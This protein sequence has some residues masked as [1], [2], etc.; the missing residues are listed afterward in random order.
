VQVF[1]RTR[2][3]LAREAGDLPAV[4]MDTDNDKVIVCTAP[5]AMSCLNE[6]KE[7]QMERKEKTYKLDGVFPEDA[8]QKDVFQRVGLP[9]L[10]EVMKG[11]NGCIFAY[12]QTGSGKTHS[13][14]NTEVSEMEQVGILPRLV[15]TLYA[16]AAM[17]KVHV[18]SVKAAGFQVYNEQVDDLLHPEHKRGKGA[19]LSINK[20]GG[21]PDLTWVECSSPAA[22]L[23]LFKKARHGLFYA[24]TSMN[25]ASS[26]SHAVFQIR[27]VRRKRVKQDNPD[28]G[29]SRTMQATCGQLSV[30]DLAGSERVKR[31]GVTGSNFKEATNINGSLL[32]LGNVI[33]A[34]ADKRKHI[35]FR[36]SKLTRILEGSVGGN[37]KTSLLV[38]VSPADT[39]TS[40]TLSTLEFASRAMC[41]EVDAKVNETVV[42]IDAARLA[43]DMD[44]TDGA[45]YVD[46]EMMK[47]FKESELALSE[48]KA[49]AAEQ[50]AAAQTLKAQVGAM[51]TELSSKNR[52]LADALKANERQVSQIDQLKSSLAEESIKHTRELE[53]ARKEHA[54]LQHQV[55]FAERDLHQT[56]QSLLDLTRKH[57]IEQNERQAVQK[58]L[59]TLQA[60]AKA[61]EERAANTIR[62]LETDNAT[63]RSDFEAAVKRHEAEQAELTVKI[64]EELRRSEQLEENIKSLEENKTAL[65]QEVNA[66]DSKVNSMTKLLSMEKDKVDRLAV[67]QQEAHDLRVQLDSHKVQEESLKGQIDQIAA[68]KGMLSEQVGSLESSCTRLKASFEQEIQIRQGLEQDKAK[69]L[70]TLR[71]AE[72]TLTEKQQLLRATETK[73]TEEI[74]AL[75]SEH[76]AS[77]ATIESQAQETL[78]KR[79]RHAAEAMQALELRAQHDQLKMSDKIRSLESRVEEQRSEFV[80]TREELEAR[81]AQELANALAREREAHAREVEHFRAQ[82]KA[83]VKERAEAEQAALEREAEL[84]NGHKRNIVRMQVA[85]AAARAGQDFQ[86]SHLRARF[87]KLETRFRARESRR[88]DLALIAQQQRDINEMR[89]V[90]KQARK[91]TRQKQLE[92]EHLQDNVRI[93][94]T[95]TDRPATAGQSGILPGQKVGNRA[96]FQNRKSLAPDSWGVASTH[97]LPRSKPGAVAERAASV[98][99]AHFHAAS[100]ARLRP[101]SAAGTGRT[102]TPPLTAAPSGGPS[103]G[104][105]RPLPVPPA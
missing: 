87:S 27:V 29:A 23:D 61:M 64:A 11:F 99:P 20:G 62:K 77:V 91:Q 6:T 43:A 35:P 10:V 47:T 13:L 104:R 78:D 17:D 38:C 36:D 53:L 71:E 42:E 1:A 85:N 70:S 41:V 97:T 37:C 93:F 105:S 82:I 18:Y 50:E 59:E 98:N 55:T 39:S 16:R 3:F 28:G 54:K 72:Q 45:Q 89:K 67:I 30:V 12:G 24:E 25:K 19:N 49:R 95:P 69:L 56:K 101:T 9:V 48:A 33:Q 15:A 94:G 84:E 21:M 74:E 83:A 103:G 86:H 96:S 75:I 32:A 63:L 26:R 51:E 2:P 66:L 88:E 58:R 52:T 92:L 80:A 100:H 73:H 40:E 44:N 4:D 90:V 68:E 22:L 31:S 60:E 46:E 8:S 57:V 14:L 76:R 65:T 79:S 7:V 5:D 102:E 81:Y 34:L